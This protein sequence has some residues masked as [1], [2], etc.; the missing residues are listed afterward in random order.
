MPGPRRQQRARGKDE[1]PGVLV[2]RRVRELRQARGWTQETLAKLAGLSRSYVPKLEAGFARNPT[3]ETI[4]RLAAVLGVPPEE[5]IGRPGDMPRPLTAEDLRT[6]GRQLHQVAETLATI[7]HRLE[8]AT[9]ISQDHLRRLL[10]DLE[11]AV[12][13]YGDRPIQA[14]DLLAVLKAELQELIGGGGDGDPDCAADLL[15]LARGD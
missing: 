11:T 7:A 13:A 10:L 6:V 15:R 2:G 14:Q 3:W 4:Q 9:V 12:A 8:T 5:L 1:S